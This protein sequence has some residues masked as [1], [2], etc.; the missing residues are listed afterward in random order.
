MEDKKIV[1]Q[2]I[3]LYN[4]KFFN[5]TGSVLDLFPNG[6]FFIKSKKYLKLINKDIS[7]IHI[8]ISK[9]LIP[10]SFRSEY[11]NFYPVDDVAY[12]FGEVHNYI[13]KDY[14]LDG[15]QIHSSSFIHDTVDLKSE[16]I[17]LYH[18][19]GGV[20]KQL[21]HISY[22]IV[23]SNTTIGANTVIHKG[24]LQPTIIGHNV[25]I[26]SLVNIGHNCFIDDHT[27]ITPGCVLCGRVQIGK[28]CWVGVNSSFKHGV[29]ICDNVVIGQHSN[30]R[31]DI[32]EP[33]IYAGDPIR[34]IKDYKEGWNF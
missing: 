3:E 8:V 26:G 23:K 27:V 34:K 17:H 19:P 1:E 18:T 4:R 31:H 20:K 6:L 14:K 33:G 15:S 13:F 12:V 7:N 10:T 29:K 28:N 11:E 22:V 16:G 21:K 24:V 30:V 32:I 5:T 25:T 9:S 2:L